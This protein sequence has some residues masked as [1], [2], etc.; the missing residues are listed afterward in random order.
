VPPLAYSL[1]QSKENPHVRHE[2]AHNE[3]TRR[4]EAGHAGC[5]VLDQCSGSIPALACVDGSCPLGCEAQGKSLRAPVRLG[6]Q[7]GEGKAGRANV[8]ESLMMLR[9][10]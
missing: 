7:P 9:Y 5:V 8:S 2:V 10:F 6:E 3:R 4:L 1:I